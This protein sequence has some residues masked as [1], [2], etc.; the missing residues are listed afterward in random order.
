MPVVSISLNL[1][2]HKQDLK[3]IKSEMT[4]SLHIIANLLGHQLGDI[5]V[6]S[7]LDPDLIT[8]VR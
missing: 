7:I 5:R 4:Y 8:I 3:Y 1:A 2:S 6:V